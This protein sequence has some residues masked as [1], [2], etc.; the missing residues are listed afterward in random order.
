MSEM[1]YETDGT[2]VYVGIGIALVGA[3]AVPGIYMDD[4][5]YSYGTGM[6]L[7]GV[8]GLLFI[9]WAMDTNDEK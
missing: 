6:V 2:L 3:I 5:R 9:W 1:K 8:G 7:S 4:W